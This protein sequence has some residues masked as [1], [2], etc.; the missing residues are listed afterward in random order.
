M[1]WAGVIIIAVLLV[2][3]IGLDIAALISI[4]RYYARHGWSA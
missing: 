2:V 1:A 3:G 4:R